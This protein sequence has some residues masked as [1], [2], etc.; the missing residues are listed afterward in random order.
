MLGEK[1][2]EKIIG[3]GEKLATDE[4]CLIRF[5]KLGQVNV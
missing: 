2:G 1:G 3:Y 4:N 5:E